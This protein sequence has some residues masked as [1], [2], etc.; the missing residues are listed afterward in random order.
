MLLLTHESPHRLRLLP[1][2][3]N[4]QPR[5]KSHEFRRGRRLRR[6]DFTNHR[7]DGLGRPMLIWASRLGEILHKHDT[8]WT[9]KEV[10]YLIEVVQ[11]PIPLQVSLATLRRV[12]LIEQ[13]PWSITPWTNGL[14]LLPRVDP[15]FKDPLQFVHRTADRIWSVSK[16]KVRHL[17]GRHDKGVAIRQVSYLLRWREPESSKHAHI[18]LPPNPDSDCLKIFLLQ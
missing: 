4:L 17:R 10:Q 11:A 15:E 13:T 1:R 12:V 5:V 18:K 2:R 7:W 8:P 3:H 9:G 16:V 6:H 14:F